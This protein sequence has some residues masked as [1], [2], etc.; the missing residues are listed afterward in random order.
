MLPWTLANINLLAIRIL[1]YLLTGQNLYRFNLPCVSKIV[2]S[3]FSL[4]RSF[5]SFQ[6][7]FQLWQ[8]IITCVSSLCKLYL[9]FHFSLSRESHLS[10]HRCFITWQAMTSFR[11][12]LS[13]FPC[14]TRNRN[15]MLPFKP[16]YQHVC[17]SSCSSYIFY[18]TK[19][20]NFITNRH[21]F[22]GDHYLYSHDLYDHL[23]KWLCK[24]NASHYWA[25]RSNTDL[26]RL[27]LSNEPLKLHM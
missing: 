11:G 25:Q 9:S 21:I 12:L 16:Q 13:L 14:R 24:A 1:N 18:A 10:K 4:R 19:R 7:F 20:E 2:E 3:L 6:V 22:Y 8:W 17:S 15:L 27:Y 26:W 5:Y 23:R